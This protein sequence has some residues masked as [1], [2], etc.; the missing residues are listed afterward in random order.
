MAN[1]SSFSIT[2]IKKGLQAA[3]SGM[4]L[5]ELMEYEIEACLACVAT[6]ER[7]E[8]L[9]VFENRKQPE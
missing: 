4:S 3:S 1:N 5:E 9:K 6:K 2:T 7:E 8:A